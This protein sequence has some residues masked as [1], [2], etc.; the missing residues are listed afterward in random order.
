MIWFVFRRLVDIDTTQRFV[1]RGLVD[2]DTT[3]RCLVD[4]DTTQRPLVDIDTTQ[5]LKASWVIMN[6]GRK[7]KA[8]ML[9]IT[10]A[11]GSGR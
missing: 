8:S 1:F 9:A 7:L 6:E 4:I 10:F 3:Q 2:I 11:C 5:R